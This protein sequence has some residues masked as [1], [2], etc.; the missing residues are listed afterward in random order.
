MTLG[1]KLGPKNAKKKVGFFET[2]Y[3][4]NLNLC[5]LS[6][7]LYVRVFVVVCSCVFVCAS[8]CV[9]VCM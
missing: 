7:C 1:W 2:K 8:V 3:E 5:C 9:S 6:K 4:L